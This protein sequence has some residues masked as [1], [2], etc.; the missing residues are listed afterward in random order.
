MDSKKLKLLTAMVLGDGCLTKIKNKR[1]L[2]LSVKHCAEQLGWLQYKRDLIEEIFDVQIAIRSSDTKLN[3]KIFQQYRF[4]ISRAGDEVF[5]YLKD[6]VYSTGKR[7]PTVEALSRIDE[8][9]L[10]LLYLD[11][12]S[13]GFVPSSSKVSNVLSYNLVICCCYPKEYADMMASVI[14]SKFGF[15]FNTYQD[16]PGKDSYCLRLL[17]KDTERFI[18]MVKPLIDKAPCMAYK[19][20]SLKSQECGTPEL[21]IQDE[22]IVRPLRKLRE[23]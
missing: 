16:E 15:H 4:R 8:H 3:G 7:R 17:S 14:K 1:S 5:E 18:D 12:G 23:E 10:A 6:E 2:Q 13:L 20:R 22:D 9:G 11:N 21:I 19:V